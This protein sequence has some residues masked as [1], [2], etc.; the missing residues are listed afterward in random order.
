[1]KKLFAVAAMAVPLMTVAPVSAH[2]MA[3]GILSDDLYQTIEEN[4]AGSPHLELDLTTVGSG[5]ATMAVITVTVPEADVDE[6]LATIGDV[7]AGQ[8]MQNGSSLDVDISATGTEDLVTIVVMENIG[9]GES[10]VP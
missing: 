6:V 2:H 9:Q 5:A 3:E 8:G 4:L 1:M 7:L 10:Q